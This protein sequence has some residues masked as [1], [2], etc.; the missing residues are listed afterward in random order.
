LVVIAYGNIIPQHIL[1]IPAIAPI[2]VHGSL[3]PAYRGASPIQSV[4]LDDQPETGITIMRMDAG[5]DTGP[6][7]RAQGFPLTIHT[8]ALDIIHKFQEFGP[9]LLIDTMVDY[10]HGKA[11]EIPQLQSPMPPET[12]GNPLEWKGETAKPRGFCSKLEKTHGLIN[13]WTQSLYEIN[14]IYRGCY[15][16]PKTYFILDESWG[17]HAGKQIIIDTLELDET[18]REDNKDKPLLVT[19]SSKHVTNDA[20]IQLLIKPE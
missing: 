5:L 6:M 3:L 15:L 10:A 18:K 8:T 7:L 14:N 20:I 13:P 2:N 19:R 11:P 9:Q 16:R 4:L 12:K 17:R 1:D